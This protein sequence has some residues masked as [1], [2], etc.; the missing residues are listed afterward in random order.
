MPKPRNQSPSESSMSTDSLSTDSVSKASEVKPPELKPPELKPPE[1][2]PPE[3]KLPELKPSAPRLV[4]IINLSPDSFSGDGIVA[5]SEQSRVD[6]VLRRAEQFLWEGAHA[7]D[8]GAESSRPGAQ[9]IGAQA[10]RALLLP[11]LRAVRKRFPQCVLSVDSWRLDTARAALDEGADWLNDIA[12]PLSSPEATNTSEHR[13]FEAWASLVRQNQATRWILMDNRAQWGQLGM[14]GMSYT[15]PTRNEGMDA[16]V[17]TLRTRV[18]AAEALGVLRSQ[19]IV[20]GGIGFG[21]PHKLNLELARRGAR[22][23][24]ALGCEVMVGASRK[25]FIGRVSTSGRELASPVP[26]A[27]RLGGS[28]V[29]ALAAAHDGAHFLR[30]HDV[31]ATHDAL[32]MSQ[33]LGLTHPPTTQFKPVPITM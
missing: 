12:P 23:L 22:A 5:D 2:K 13:S 31:A 33:A 30:V 7:L 11:C 3:L 9:P 21:K 10:E 20:D 16:I 8:L 24:S 26:V 18:E 6:T 4:A 27:R 19:L 29:C 1:L 17:S 14:D 28:L 32:A 25:S 15:P